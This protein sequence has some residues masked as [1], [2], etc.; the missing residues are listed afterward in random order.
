MKALLLSTWFPYPPNQGSKTRA[1]HLLRALA[2]K[3]EITLVSFQDGE[4]RPEW[5]RHVQELCSAVHV[6]PREPFARPRHKAWLGWLSPDPS[7]V[8]A[9]YSRRMSAQVRAAAE[10]ASPDVVIAL[11]FAMAPYALEIETTPKIV[12]VDNLLAPMLYE[13]YLEITHPLARVRRYVAYQKLRRYESRIYR[14]FD[15]CLVAAARD[16][17]RIAEYV[18][19]NDVQIEVFS[20]GV[21]I[22]YYSVLPRAEA[23]ESLVFNGALT[24]EPNFEAMEYFLGEIFPLV[25]RERPRA[26]LAITGSTSGVQLNK[27]APNGNVNYTGYLEDIR[28][29][30]A[31]SSICVA[32]LR[33]GAGTRL[34][35]LEAM[36][37]RTPV[38]ST[39]K[40]AEGLEVEHDVHLLTADRPEEFAGH[41][42]QLLEDRE[43]GERLSATAYCRVKEKYDW[44]DIG[45]R[46][47]TRIEAL[48]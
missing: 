40:G 37:L 21:D 5:L 17:V 1:Y 15:L 42:I 12:D 22:A 41:V 45:R 20:N 30:V 44:D 33:K 8:V 7:A 39:S 18:P 47:V 31:S 11:T 14:Q 35:I 43:L 13:K 26:S 27:L 9:G 2:R 24:Y 23:E 25:L 19:I 29:I 32:P 28:D 10:S 3:H 6:V 48:A 46:L 16:A 4:L 34:K 36:A 38:V